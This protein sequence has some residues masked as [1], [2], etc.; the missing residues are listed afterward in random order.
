MLKIDSTTPSAKFLK[1]ISDTDITR[2]DA[3][4]I[5]QLRIGHAPLN[6]YL[7]RFKRVGSARCPACGAAEETVEHFLLKCEGYA[8]ERQSLERKLKR[9]K[10]KI[11]QETLLGNQGAVTLL[12]KYIVATHC[13]DRPGEPSSNTE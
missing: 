7:H 9:K 2:S 6:A 5:S 11:N 8:Y 3:S 10:M 4:I 1:L 12:A 13:F